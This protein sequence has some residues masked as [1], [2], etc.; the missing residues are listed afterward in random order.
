MGG[1]PPL[2]DKILTIGTSVALL[3]PIGWIAKAGIVTAFRI[4]GYLRSEGEDDGIEQ[5]R[6]VSVN[7]ASNVAAVPVVYGRTKVGV[8]IMDARL[9]RGRS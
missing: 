3:S 5:Q 6:G 2:I 9:V 4:Q 8:E 1:G 7:V